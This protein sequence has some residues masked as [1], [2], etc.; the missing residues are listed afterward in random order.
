[1]SSTAAN[2]A[3]F[4]LCLALMGSIPAM[5]A[6][7]KA[8]QQAEVR[9]TSQSVLNQ[10]YRAKPSARAAV[11][12]AVGYATFRNFGMKLFFCWL[13]QQMEVPECLIMARFR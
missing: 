12:A 10:L 7:S 3:A 11:K 13:R 4:V 2:N 8:Q 1:M 6:A 9:K 5:A